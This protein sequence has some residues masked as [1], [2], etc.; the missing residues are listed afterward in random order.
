MYCE[1]KFLDVLGETDNELTTRQVCNIIG[2]GVQH[3]LNMLKKLK[4]DGKIEGR[5][6]ATKAF[7]W[8]GMK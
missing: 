2:C 5:Q 7:L 4:D 1:H 6:L 3:G 8:K